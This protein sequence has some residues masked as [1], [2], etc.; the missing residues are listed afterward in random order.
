MKETVLSSQVLVLN[1]HYVPIHV[2]GLKHA[3]GMIYRG[4][5]K[6]IDKEYSLF[7]FK[8]W[9]SLEISPDEERIGLINGAI[10]VPRVILLLLYEKIP[11]RNLRFS[12]AN[13]FLRDQHRC[14][15]CAKI[16]SRSELNLDHVLPVSMGGKTRWDN[17]V[18]SCISCN[19]KKGGRTP[20]QAKM[21]LYK[22]PVRPSWTFYF[23]HMV[24]P[25]YF[26][27]WL[28]FLSMIDFTA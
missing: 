28:P 13:I 19:V 11:K 20:E 16:F 10:R 3:L 24:R 14:Q 26:Q 22:K 1:R 12:R 6:I 27:E 17:V 15:Y 4:V 5:A 9:S 25:S 2:V 8:S 7:D 18:C 23:I 21:Q